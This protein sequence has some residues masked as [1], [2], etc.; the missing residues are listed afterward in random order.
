MY[1]YL[2][3]QALYPEGSLR[4]LGASIGRSWQELV[5]WVSTLPEVHPEAMAFGLM[6]RRLHHSLGLGSSVHGFSPTCKSCAAETVAHF[7]GNEAELLAA[8][9]KALTEINASL[10]NIQMRIHRREHALARMVA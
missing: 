7:H 10:G 6:I 3:Q 8:Y 5:E 1:L 9:D 4:R 2:E